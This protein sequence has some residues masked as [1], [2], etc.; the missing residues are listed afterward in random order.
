M[1]GSE[2]VD[3]AKVL[4]FTATAAR[5]RRPV[6]AEASERGTILF[7]TGVRYERPCAAETAPVDRA[8]SPAP[9]AS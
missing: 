3:G 5:V 4:R 7:F 2:R 1:I 8:T 6:E 9:R